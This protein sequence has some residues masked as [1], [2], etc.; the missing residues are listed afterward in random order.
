MAR[1]LPLEGA[2]SVQVESQRGTRTYPKRR[3]GSIEVPER[4]AR[5]LLREG[6]ATPGNLAGPTV[7]M[8][9]GYTCRG[10]GRGF[11]LTFDPPKAAGVCDACGGELYQR[12]DDQPETVARRLEVYFA[13]TAPL[14]D[15]YRDSGLLREVA[16]EQ[17]IEAVQSDILDVLGIRVA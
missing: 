15:Y 6:L 5:A 1:L 9:G 8:A 7:D 13:Q 14:I 12:P 17:D 3:D 11:H 2:Y 16:G 10:C 4:D